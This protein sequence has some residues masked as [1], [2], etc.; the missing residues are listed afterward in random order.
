MVFQGIDFGL[1]LRNIVKDLLDSMISRF[2]PGLPLI[3]KHLFSEDVP[4][5]S[6]IPQ[7]VGRI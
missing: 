3:S 5:T 4:P 1:P 2:Q 7:A 6:T